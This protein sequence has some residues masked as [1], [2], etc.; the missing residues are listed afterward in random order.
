MTTMKACI[1]DSRG[2]DGLTRFGDLPKPT[3][4]KGY[5]VVK[6]MAACCNPVDYKLPHFIMGGIPMG[7]DVAGIV[8]TSESPL[9]KPGDQVFGNTKSAIAEYSLCDATHLAK[10]PAYLTWAQAA[11]MPLAFV[12]SYQA[13]K[14][15]CDFDLKDKTV[16]VIGAS[17][18]CGSAG[19]ILA[20]HMGAKDVVGVCSGKNADFV[21]GLGATDI[22]DYKSEN[23]L[24]KYGAKH[25]DVVYDCASSSGG[26]ENYFEESFK[27]LKDEGQIVALNGPP[28]SWVRKFIRWEAKGM[29]LLLT[30]NTDA[31]T[32]LENIFQICGPGLKPPVHDPV[33]SFDQ[34][35]L[36]AGYK[37]LQSRRA[38][39]K[40]AFNVGGW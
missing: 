7:F 15:Y 26:G 10:K 13:Y 22:C 39:G 30:D 18:G 34:E 38:Q 12:T 31:K 20:K 19:V 5:V 17:G 23:I 11:A 32:T 28:T 2:P 1:R 36:T 33:Y 27:V 3:A 14:N 25:F 9:Y 35:G 40:V 21:R 24:D 6:V 4:S 37:M 8:E 16:L 29:K